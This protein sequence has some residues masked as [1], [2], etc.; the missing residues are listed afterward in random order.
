MA[1]KIGVG[2][3]GASASRGWSLVAHLPALKAIP[4]YEVRAVAGSSTQ[5]AK[6]AAE[7]FG[8][9]WS[10]AD[11][12][13]MI[14]NPDVDLVVV[15]IKAPQHY[16]IVMRALTAGKMV[17]CEWPLGRN[18]QEASEMATLARKNGVATLIGLQM[19]CTPV[20]RY[21][22]SLVDDDYVGKVL[23]TVIVGSGILINGTVH[24]AYQYTLDPASGATLLT[25]PAGHAADTLCYV[26]G[27]F[28]SISSTLVVRHEMV[29][30]LEDGILLPNASPDQLS[31]SG[32]LES[33][34][35]A[36]IH[37][38]GNASKDD[39]FFWRI[40][41]TKGELRLSLENGFLSS[42]TPPSSILRLWGSRGDEQLKELTMP[43]DQRYAPA[44]MP[45]GPGV[46][47]AE[48]YMQFARDRRDGT[49]EAPDFAVALQR[50]R[51]IDAVVRADLTGHRQQV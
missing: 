39:D 32:V 24:E 30:R 10:Y 37:Y 51:M 22:K 25:V 6:A 5:S 31:F 17:F 46:H 4:E 38:Q 40:N 29:T 27:E 45:A 41:G 13:E 11:A 47:V 50:H 19:R 36:T 34:A 35:L 42:S 49:N 2:I 1:E 18:L 8:A 44:D 43:A 26:L 20:I 7:V 23:S 33:G 15:C 21:L 48:L 9:K 28:R 14:D 3:V 12:G 16:D